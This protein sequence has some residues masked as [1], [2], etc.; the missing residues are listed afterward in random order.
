MHVFCNFLQVCSND[1]NVKK[2]LD[3]YNADIVIAESSLACLIDNHGPLFG[4]Q[5]EM[6][7]K[8]VLLPGKGKSKPVIC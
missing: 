7:V 1:P 8:I 3:S 2:L 5:W 6:P 4:R